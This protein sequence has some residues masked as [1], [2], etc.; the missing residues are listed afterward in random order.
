MAKA[1]QLK[2]SVELCTLHYLFAAQSS[3]SFNF[4]WRQ[5]ADNIFLKKIFVPNEN[6]TTV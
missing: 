4:C 1:T 3:L 5:H 2:I 6:N